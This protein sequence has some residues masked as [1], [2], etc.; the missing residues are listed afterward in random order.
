MI[1]F[2]QWRAFRSGSGKGGSSVVRDRDTRAF[3]NIIDLLTYSD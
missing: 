2:V 1:L 3:S